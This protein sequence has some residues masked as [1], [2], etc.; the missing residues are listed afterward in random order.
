MKF[1]DLIKVNGQDGAHTSI[2][3]AT[4][5]KRL[6]SL[7]TILNVVRMTNASL[8]LS[9]LLE[10]VIDQA[11]RIT[12][13]ERGFLM[14]AGENRAL[15]FVVGRDREGNQIHPENF[16]VSSSVLEDVFSTGESICIESA[17][18]DERFERRAS[19]QNLELQTIMCAPL[20]TN[21]E[22]IGV[23][24]VDS[25][26]IQAIDKE[27]V[28]YLFEILAG[29]AAIAIQNARLYDDLKRTYEQLKQ[30]N[31]QIIKS[32]KMA[33]RGEL[34]AEVSHELKNLVAVILLQLHSLQKRMSKWETN[35]STD[36]INEIIQS[37]H[38]INGF[39]ENLLVRSSITPK[40]KEEDLNKLASDFVAFI[41]VLPKFRQARVVMQADQTLPKVKVDREQLQQVLLNL[42]NNAVESYSEATVRFKTEYDVLKNVVCLSV[43]D[44]GK[45]LDPRIKDKIL[46]EK[47]TTKENGHGYGLNICRKIIENHGGRIT[48]ESEPCKGTTFTMRFPAS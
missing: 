19:V 16:Q 18:T 32:E 5:D 44:N 3:T 10:L 25:R 31:E 41:S 33:L 26:H 48:V 46:V 22:T 24:Y 4:S 21:E 12:N 13:A 39:S 36:L 2:E 11:I 30:A 42:A 1:T 7:E 8:V 45:G 9:E 14:L 38:R 20:K 6:Q 15:Q 34:A 35:Q 27:D 47:V 40:M 29:Q 43:S 17:L 37:V 23:I 28:L